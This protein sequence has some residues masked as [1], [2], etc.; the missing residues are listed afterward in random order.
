[1]NSGIV[2]IFKTLRMPYGINFFKFQWHTTHLYIIINNIPICSH[3]IYFKYLYTYMY[4]NSLSDTANTNNYKLINIILLVSVVFYYSLC[5]GTV[6]LHRWHGDK[7]HFFHIIKPI[8]L[9]YTV[10]YV[11][12]SNLQWPIV[13]DFLFSRPP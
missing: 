6:Y 7:N 1:M 13:C 11:L 5:I 2:K 9:L 4:W 8:I 10:V 3:H 12:T